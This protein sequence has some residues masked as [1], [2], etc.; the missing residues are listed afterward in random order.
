MPLNELRPELEQIIFATDADVARMFKSMDDSLLILKNLATATD[1]ESLATIARNR[2]YLC[3]CL[4]YQ[5]IIEAGR[6]LQPY[7]DGCGK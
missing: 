6:D 2:D 3:I 4:S 5:T 7:I 1:E